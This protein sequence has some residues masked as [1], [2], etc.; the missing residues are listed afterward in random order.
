MKRDSFD[1]IIEA[2]GIIN[3]VKKGVN[4]ETKKL[5]EEAK[6]V[7]KDTKDSVDTAVDAVEDG[8]DT[9]VD[10]VD[11]GI[12]MIEDATLNGIMTAVNS[13]IDAINTIVK[14]ITGLDDY[15]NQFWDAMTFLDDYNQ[16]LAV[17][18]TITIPFFGQL[19]ARFMLYNGSM[20]NPYMFLFFFPPLTIYPAVAMMFGFF[21]DGYS[22]A[23]WDY[24]I[25]ILVVVNAIGLIMSS[26]F[27]SNMLASL[28]TTG[29]F[30]L[31]YWYKSTDM[32]SDAAP[33][34]K[35]I[36]DSILSYPLAFILTALL[37]FI[38]FVGFPFKIIKNFVP[39]GNIINSS[40]AITFVYI[41]MNIINAT[42]GDEHCK[43]VI[44]DD[45][46]YKIMIAGIALAAIIAFGP[47]G[48]DIVTEQAMNIGVKK[49]GQMGQLDMNQPIGELGLGEI[50]KGFIRM[51]MKTKK[52]MK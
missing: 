33:T 35:L 7:A 49:M 31:T 47:S 32:C 37:P 1:K 3:T 18:L 15:F 41:I 5:K 23:P 9:A 13:I 22:G 48:A 50:M 42:L 36:V 19:I 21:N 29:A 39:F 4:K 30:F 27:K 40:F 45:D 11:D 12:K 51:A 38:P 26:G 8:V 25:W 16:A 10:A 6:K 46:I 52:M 44:S 28:F 2:F 17:L 24:S 20:A 43:A 34:N 14:F